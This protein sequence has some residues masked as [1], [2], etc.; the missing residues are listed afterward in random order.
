MKKL[1]ARL[2]KAKSKIS[3]R[4]YKQP[5]MFVIG[6]MVLINLV[7][8]VVAALIAV[9]IDD[10]FDNWIDAFAN[11]SLKWMLTPNAILEI[12]HPETLFLAVV[13]LIIGIVLFSGTII[14]LTTNAIKDYFEKK[15]SGSGKIHLDQHIVIL[16]WN[17]KVP[18][19]VSDLIYVDDKDVTV[20]ILADIDKFYA[21]RQI[22]NAL[23]K[24]DREA[25]KHLN[26]LVKR[27]D[28]M[29][30]QN[31]ADITIDKAQSIII[32]NPESHDLVLGDMSK[33]DLSVI[34]VILALGPIDFI[35]EP[36]IVVEIKHYE[37]KK[38]IEILSN[39]VQSLYEHMILPVCF[40][41]RLG[42]IIAQTLI[43]HRME[44]IYLS[45]FSFDGSEVY[46]LPQTSFKTCIDHHSHA[47]PLARHG[48]GLFVL[49]LTD[50]SKRLQTEHAFEP[51]KLNVK[52]ID[53]SVE[54]S[55]YIIGKNNKL[56]FILDSFTS[57]QHIHKSS[58]KAQWID[59]KD[60]RQLTAKLNESHERAAILLLSDENQDSDALDANVINNLIYFEGNLENPHANVICELLDPTNDPIV[61]GFNVKNTIISNKIIS[62]LIS[63]LALFKETAAFYEDL[64]TIEA[65]EAGTDDQAITIKS[66]HEII[67][68]AFP[69]VFKSKKQLIQ[70]IDHA[71]DHVFAILGYYHDEK[72][73]ILEGD[74]HVENDVSIESDDALILMRI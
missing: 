57:Y 6:I 44:D 67:D 5:L 17:N 22:V 49:S 64:L 21:E 51:I 63:K 34:K 48:D 42:Q 41:K 55:V 54:L 28:P 26:V 13:V 20:M 62:L 10:G 69:I 52:P 24:E 60:I 23:K 40:D 36:P 65:N 3:I 30:H 33:S 71:F 18:E 12:E 50:Q 31:L 9:V 59:D 45:L 19:L 14:A 32:M 43:D 53:E 47:I 74:L 29:L 15:K 27:G 56:Q 68:H 16:N 25:I 37:T 70:S 1:K 2:A 66:A 58:F 8:L 39:K 4:T 35:Y 11:G 46:Y 38:K 73:V 72:L 7:I 61:R